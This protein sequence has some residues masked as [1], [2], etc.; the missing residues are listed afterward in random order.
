[1]T[2]ATATTSIPFLR[3]RR[4]VAAWAAAL[5]LGGAAI[6]TATTL[7]VTADD[8]SVSKA[9]PAAVVAN[10]AVVSSPQNLPK[11]ADA[12]EHWVSNPTDEDHIFAGHA[13]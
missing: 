8:D 10:P 13:R 2:A 3:T 11:T 9:V 4:R 5:L 6:G 12:A 7:A 1:M